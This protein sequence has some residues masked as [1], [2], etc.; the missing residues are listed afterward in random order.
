MP[1]HVRMFGNKPHT[2]NEDVVRS[3]IQANHNAA[4]RDSA[5]PCGEL[6]AVFSR[7]FASTGESF[8]G[9]TMYTEKWSFANVVTRTHLSHLFFA[10][11]QFV[12]HF[13]KWRSVRA[14]PALSDLILTLKGQNQLY[15]HFEG[16]LDPVEKLNQHELTGSHLWGIQ[17]CH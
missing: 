5:H 6:I 11:Q 13:A 16:L 1:K 8:P 9:I 2:R 10:T 12:S 14:H 7:H 17:M 3:V 15:S 4:C